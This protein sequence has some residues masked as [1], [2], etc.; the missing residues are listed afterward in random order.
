MLKCWACS[1]HLFLCNQ[2]CQA[3]WVET[4]TILFTDS[5]GKEF[6]QFQLGN[7]SVPHGIN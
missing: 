1:R 7:S 3:E 2:L 5:V 6:G 4:T